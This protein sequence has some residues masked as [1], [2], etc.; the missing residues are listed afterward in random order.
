MIW[1]RILV[2]EE[3]PSE[4]SETVVYPT[5]AYVIPNGLPSCCQ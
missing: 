2:T 4:P 3:S 1:G 5:E